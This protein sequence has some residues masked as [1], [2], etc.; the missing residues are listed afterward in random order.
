GSDVLKVP[1]LNKA[2]NVAVGYKKK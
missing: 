2:G 1:G